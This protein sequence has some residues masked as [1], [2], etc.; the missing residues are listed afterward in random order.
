MRAVPSALQDKLDAG[1][2]TLCWCWR[3]QRRDGLVL[4][5]TDHDED[6]TLAGET[7]RAASALSG[8][9]IERRTGFAPGQGD[10]IGTLGADALSEADLAAGLFDEADVTLYRADWSEPS[11]FVHVWTGF[12]AD[13]VRSEHGFRAELRGPAARLEQSVGRLYTRRCSAELGDG[14]CGVDLG[15]P[16]LSGV[17]VLTAAEGLRLVAAG[18]ESIPSGDLDHGVLTWTSGPNAGARARIASWRAPADLELLEAP[19]L[20]PSPG[21]GFTVTA[22]CDKVWTTCRDRFA[23][24]LNFRGF[25]DMPGNDHLL[26]AVREGARHDGASRRG[27]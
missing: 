15:A 2:A 8:S 19:R 7:Y 10:A 16:G 27:G 6:L 14:R 22:G 17:G 20:A 11:L 23:N 18:L 13:I 24:L 21:D 3:V 9:D 12:I 4:G 26:A 5:F 25:P 1:V